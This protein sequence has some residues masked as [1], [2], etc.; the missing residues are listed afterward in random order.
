MASCTWLISLREESI[1]KDLEIR[2]TSESNISKDKV[3]KSMTFRS[4]TKLNRNGLP[5]FTT[6]AKIVE[7]PDFTDQKLSAPTECIQTNSNGA[8]FYISMSWV[9]TCSPTANHEIRT[10]TC[11]FMQNN[12]NDYQ[13]IIDG[14]VKVHVKNQR[15]STEYA[16]YPD[17]LAT[18]SCFNVNIVIYK[19]AEERWDVITPFK[20]FGERG[21]VYLRYIE[22]HYMVVTDVAKGFLT[23]RIN[24]NQP[25]EPITATT[26]Q[27]SDN[28]SRTLDDLVSEAVSQNKDCDEDNDMNDT[29]KEDPYLFT[30]R[31]S[32]TM[33]QYQILNKA[34]KQVRLKQVCL[35]QRSMQGHI[36]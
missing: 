16:D 8:C 20:G 5:E 28:D 3:L 13:N 11:D 32:T 1:H 29:P 31:H 17:I 14:P 35:K 7:F 15:K 26:P 34:Q 4:L 23:E 10:M 30:S 22:D 6:A 18:A 9:M 27:K 25:E 33:T 24:P 12:A 21:N 19:H 2:L 36:C